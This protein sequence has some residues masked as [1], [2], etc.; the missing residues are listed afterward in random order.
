VISVFWAVCA[1]TYAVRARAGASDRTPGLALAIADRFVRTHHNLKP[2]PLWVV[3][4]PPLTVSKSWVATSHRRKCGVHFAVASVH[5]IVK[6]G[7]VTLEGVVDN[8]SDKA[9][10]D[11]RAN[12]VGNV[13]SV[14]NNLK[15]V[16]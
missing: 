15:V 13:F 8:Q 12:S 11:I 2:L 9:A 4:S 14:T 1:M 6:G 16:K 7:H 10:A 5:I 3:V